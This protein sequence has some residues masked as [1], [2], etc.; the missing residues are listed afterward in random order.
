VCIS[1]QRLLHFES[2]LSRQTVHIK[3]HSA[4]RSESKLGRPQSSGQKQP[5]EAPSRRI[6][7]TIAHLF[8]E[9]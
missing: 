9:S 3:Q 2:A 7:S 5:R 1:T 6:V 8:W 4:Q